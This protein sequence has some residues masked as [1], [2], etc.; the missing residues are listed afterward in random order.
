MTNQLQ[1]FRNSEFGELSVMQIDGKEYFPATECAKVLGYKDAINA[2]KQHCR[3]VVKH[4]LPHPQSPNK[5][6]EANFIPEGDLYR[7]IIR[8]KLPGAERF[9]RWVFEEVLPTIRKHGAYVTPA[10][11]DDILNDPDAWIKTLTVLKQERKE[12]AR[13]EVENAKKD[14]IIGE[15]KPKA[16]YVDWILKSP[17]TVA[18][19]A[20]AK[21]YGMAA[22]SMNRLLHQMGIQYKQ[23][24]QWF[25]YRKHQAKG[26]TH[27]ETVEFKRTDGRW[28][29]TMHTKWTQKGRLFLYEALKAEGIL[30]MIERG[31][32][33]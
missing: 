8:S 6:L 5:I 24:E 33:A 1:T 16:D 13:L 23:G 4:H 17:S 20:I 19:T 11:I 9:E 3:G 15:L 18:M 10:K 2:I 26:Y 29:T 12:R 22:Q 30:P 32:T 27:S 14:Q 21:D 31:Q 28:D 25:L 7:L